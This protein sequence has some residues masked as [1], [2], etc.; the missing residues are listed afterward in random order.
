M[1]TPRGLVVLGATGSVGRSTLD[2]AARHPERFRVVALTAHHDVQGLAAL[3]AQHDAAHAVIANAE[4]FDDLALALREHGSG[5]TPHAGPQALRDIVSL[6]GTHI[7]MAAI[8]G[9]AGLEPTLRAVELGHHV[10]LAN[11]ESMVIAGDLFEK[12]RQASGARLVP[13][14]SEHNALFQSLPV[15]FAERGLAAS[16]VE[17]LILTASGGPFRETPS[18]ELAAVTP[19][20][21]CAHPNWDMGRKISVDSATLMNKGLEVIEAHG[22]FGAPADMIDVV[23]H[24]QSIVHSLVAYRDGSVLAQLG[25]PDMRTPIAHALAWPERIEAGVA[26]LDLATAGRLDFHAPDL[27]RFPCLRLAFDALRA[28]GKAPAVLNA[29]N[30]IAVQAFLDAE[31]GFTRIPVIIESTLEATPAGAVASIDDVLAADQAARALARETIRK[32]SE[33]A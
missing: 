6:D 29:A 4:C 14:D 24:P 7:V 17:K 22:L 30:E 1:N 21:A 32:M 20:Q 5:A 13:V 10:A 3:C 16:G 26:R 31:I 15:D 8:V 11:K 2:V 23:V 28:G 33:H 18:A 12:A 27:D 9:A 19:E 25:M